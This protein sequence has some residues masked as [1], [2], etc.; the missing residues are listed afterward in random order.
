MTD[1]RS[2]ATADRS[3]L[4]KVTAKVLRN[5]IDSRNTSIAHQQRVA[6]LE[7]PKQD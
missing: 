5:L 6:Y 3:V 7:D 1:Q 4:L 2:L